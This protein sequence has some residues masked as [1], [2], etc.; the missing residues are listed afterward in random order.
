M[1]FL[2]YAVRWGYL[3]VTIDRAMRKT[4]HFRALLQAK[5]LGVFFVKTGGARQM[6]AWQ[7]AQLVVKAWDGMEQH[8]AQHRRPF[9][10][11]VQPNGRVLR[12]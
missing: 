12:D 9:I 2:D 7:I 4:P 8:A 10:A 3:V 6:N 1:N 5:G 11:L